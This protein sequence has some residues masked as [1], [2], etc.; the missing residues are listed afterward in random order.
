M[1]ILPHTTPSQGLTGYPADELLNK[2]IIDFIYADDSGVFVRG[3][4]IHCEWQSVA[5]FL[6]LSKEGWKLYNFRVPWAH[7]RLTV[8]GEPR[9]R[10]KQWMR[11][12]EEGHGPLWGPSPL[13]DQQEKEY[14]DTHLSANF[15][16]L[17]Q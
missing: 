8:L 12:H 16:L 9:R 6:S 1:A 4:T 7:L 10:W 13:L 3:S 15:S 11:G 2:F 17:A 5:L 14:R